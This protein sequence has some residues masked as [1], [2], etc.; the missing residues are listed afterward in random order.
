MSDL[1]IE[2]GA[3]ESYQR[4]RAGR[5]AGLVD[6]SIQAYNEEQLMLSAAWSLG[7]KAGAAGKPESDNPYT[8]EN[9]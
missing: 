4:W 3:L 9:A 6:L 7:R 1:T 8:Q 5:L 2:P